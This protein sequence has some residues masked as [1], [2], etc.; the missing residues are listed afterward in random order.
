[1]QAR[2]LLPSKVVV[3]IKRG[4][5]LL[6]HLRQ[7]ALVFAAA[8]WAS[9]PLHA[10]KVQHVA[11]DTLYNLNVEEVCQGVCVLATLNP[12]SRL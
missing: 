12:C 6:S 8:Q 3:C 1:M 4:Q 7:L 11:Q 9:V 10:G 5:V 2:L